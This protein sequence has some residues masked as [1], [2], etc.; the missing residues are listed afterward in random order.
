M[1]KIITLVVIIFVLCSIFL[2]YKIFKVEK[3]ETTSIDNIG[4]YKG[5]FYFNI[6]LIPAEKFEKSKVVKYKYKYEA[7]LL[8]DSQYI[9]LT[10]QYS[11]SEYSNEKKRLAS[12]K[13]EYAS[14]VYNDSY[15]DLP[16]Y[17][18]MY[19]VGDSNEFALV[20]DEKKQITYVYIQCPFDFEGEMYV[21]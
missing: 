14:V 4:Q 19:K 16:A 9:L 2:G 11:N 6:A 15:F 3:Y 17:I 7:S 20:D 18:Y 1:K 13:D 8:D 12:I 5:N 10:Y 21:E